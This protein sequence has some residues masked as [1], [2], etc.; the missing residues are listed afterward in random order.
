MVNCPQRL[1]RVIRSHASHF[2]QEPTIRF[3]ASGAKPW[4]WLA[5]GMH[6]A[7]LGYRTYNLREDLI[8]TKTGIRVNTMV[9][10]LVIFVG[11][12]LLL[13]GSGCATPDISPKAY[14]HEDGSGR[15]YETITGRILR[16]EPNGIVY[17]ITCPIDWRSRW[18]DS[19]LLLP[20]PIV[21]Q[22]PPCPKGWLVQLGQVSK[23]NG[24]WDMTGYNV[25]SESGTCDALLFPQRGHVSCWNRVWEI[26][27]IIL[28]FGL[29]LL[30]GG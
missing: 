8:R 16:V 9:R 21:G 15:Y 29:I 5:R 11:L 1:V 26:P 14:F 30:S 27:V 24:D 28:T 25:A 7:A 3:F 2:A 19:K 22:L 17:D 6:R 4:P 20:R 13:L 23:L 18:D 12:S 10:E